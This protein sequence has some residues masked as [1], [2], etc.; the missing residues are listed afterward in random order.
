MAILPGRSLAQSGGLDLSF[1]PSDPGFGN[2]AG[3]A[4]G[5]VEAIVVQPDGKIIIGGNFKT[6]N[7]VTVNNITR[8]NPNGSIDPTFNPGGTGFDSTVSTIALQADGKIIVG[9]DFVLYNGA[10]DTIIVRLNANGTRDPSFTRHE[11]LRHV[12]TLCIQ[13][14]GQILVGSGYSRSVIRLNTDG[15]IDGS[16]TAHITSPSPTIGVQIYSLSLQNDGKIIVG[17]TFSRD[18]GLLVTNITRL[19]TDGSR[20]ETFNN[21]T[22]DDDG[23]VGVNDWV[24][25]TAVQLDGK[26]LI[27]GSFTAHNSLAAPLTPANHIARLNTDGSLDATFN[28]GGTGPNSS[29]YAMALQLDGK[30]IIAGYFSDY[31]GNTT[32]KLAR[33][34]ADGSFDNTFVAGGTFDVNSSISR[35]AIQPDNTKLLIGGSFTSYNDIGRNR[36]ARIYNTDCA[37]GSISG[38]TRACAYRLPSGPATYTVTAPPGSTYTWT[39]SNP[40]TMLITGS[41]SSNTVLIQYT[42]SFT[43]GVVYVRVSNTSCGLLVKPY[44]SVNIN[45]PNSPSAITASHTAICPFIGTTDVVTYSIRKIAN[46]TSYT[47]LASAPATITHPNGPGVN[48][49]IVQV[50]F[51]A[52]YP[53]GE[54]DVYG[55]NECG[56]GSIRRLLITVRAPSLP[57]A[58]TGP[59]Y[60]C[61]YRAPMANSPAVYSVP[62][63]AG[64]TYNWTVPAVAI[65]LTGQ[66]TNSISFYYPPDFISGTVS[67]VAT[68]GCGTS[69][70]R[71]L[72]VKAK[73]ASTPG[74]ITTVSL[75]PCPNRTF[76]Y[77]IAAIPPDATSVSWTVPAAGLI[78]SG[79]GTNSI[80]VSY[81]SSTVGGYV[82]VYAHNTCGTSTVRKITVSLPACIGE[83]TKNSNSVPDNPLALDLNTLDVKVFPNPTVSDFQLQAITSSKEI[84]SVK[85]FEMQGRFI[86]EIFVNPN[87]TTNIGSD[88]KTGT[89]IIEVRQ[90]KNVKTTKLVKF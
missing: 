12:N 14:D 11:P 74:A 3:G 50:N 32:N 42:A 56:L 37:V 85:I 71:S 33:L 46:A 53:G 88:L 70:S 67:V 82:S 5:R 87:Q 79:Q 64:V 47:W 7:G 72:A 24:Y 38:P 45:A 22:Y 68:N 84:I 49:T 34:N 51:G 48:D 19:N 55:V 20:D 77:S 30:I 90:G 75:D 86:K 81:P 4:G 29:V 9:G 17:G 80:T 62:A 36:V 58:I 39:V 57:G 73:R 2:P 76:R 66:G 16:F 28:A 1:N 78:I 59:A 13:P 65:D 27:G 63:V 69:G 44:L 6:Y 89:Y 10:A 41:P 83:F 25:A 35:L 21:I 43:T 61:D 60:V 40:A 15:S 23:S 18:L 31:N 8:V 54:I 52:G 26:I